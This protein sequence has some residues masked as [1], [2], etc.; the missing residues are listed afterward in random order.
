MDRLSVHRVVFRP[1]IEFLFDSFADL[2]MIIRRD[3]DVSTVEQRV[4]VLTEKNAI[5]R[6]MRAA[7]SRIRADVRRVQDV[8]DM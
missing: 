7:L 4:D 8:Q 6:R 1:V 5:G 2:D 3:S